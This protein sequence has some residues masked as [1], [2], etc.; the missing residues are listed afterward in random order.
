V[1]CQGGYVVAP[2]SN[3][4]SGRGYERDAGADLAEVAIADAP[5]WLMA[6]ADQVEVSPASARTRSA[7]AFIE[8]G[9]HD[10]IVSLSG[11]LRRRGLTPAEMLPTMQAVNSARCRPPL[12]DHEIRTIAYSAKWD[13]KD[14]LPGGPEDELAPEVPFDDLWTEEPEADLVVPSLG[15]APGPVHLVTGT[16]YTGKTLFLMTMGVAVASGRD[17]FG[18][19]RTRRGKWIHFDYE[20]GRRHFKRYLKRLVA[21]SGVPVDELRDWVSVRC[22]PKLNLRS[23]AAVEH[24]TKKLEGYSICTIDPL[25][26]AAPG[27][28]ENK[29]E[30]REYLDMLAIASDRAKCSIVVLHHGGKPVEGAT[31]K[32][33][34]RG[35]SA[36]D[37][38]VQTKFVLSS[39]AK[40]APMLVSHEKTRELDQTLDDF[41]LE[42]V[43]EPGSL[44]LAHRLPNEMVEKA[45]DPMIAVKARISQVLKKHT[46][47]ASKSAV[48]ARM[49]GNRAVVF[50][51]IDE[52]F[53]EG[54]LHQDP[55]GYWHVG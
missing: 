52:M 28:D 12:D 19:W 18:V 44:R 35:T 42:F 40:G 25:R 4:D 3:H 43:A 54:V 29:S 41:Y 21:G 50:Q 17:A 49:K 37:D 13:P 33:T 8:G 45:P 53:A 24:F 1:K 7:D 46:K 23:E 14:P 26:A 5:G 36:I 48:L 10:A 55:S 20:M 16:W 6:L 2:G 34:G 38:A 11:V 32:N 51:A 22:L 15:I 9:R 39:E 27:A 47:L 31:R 30:F